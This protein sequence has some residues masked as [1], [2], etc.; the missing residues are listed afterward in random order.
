MPDTEVKTTPGA[1]GTTAKP[2][3]EGAD[4][5]T[6]GWLQNRDLATKPAN[7]VAFAAIKAAREA[8]GFVGLPADRLIRLPA[9][10][11]DTAGWGE[12]WKRLGAPV[13]GKYSF[14]GINRADGKPLD[15]GLKGA[16]NDAFAAAKVPAGAA[17][18]VAQSVVKYLDKTAIDAATLKAGTT[19]TEKDALQQNWKGNFD[20]N[21]F[22]ASQAAQK[23]GF[24]PEEIAGLEGQVGY[25]KT[26]E[27]FRSIGVTLG[28][29]RYVTGGGGNN[30]GV[31]TGEQA[32]TRINDLKKDVVWTKSYLAG[33]T[34]KVAEMSQLQRLVWQSQPDRL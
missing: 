26:M 5:D 12:V 14:E 10:Q 1:D 21:K 27:M 22:I 28:E 9:D 25:A 15:D 4:A 11:T 13:D 6:I 31:L 20:T 7:E 34:A 30:P 19:A 2:W 3:H 16:L 18:A 23:L 33:D 24:T 29:A 8:Q 32:Q 17:S